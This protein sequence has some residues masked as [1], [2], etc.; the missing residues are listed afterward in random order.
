[1]LRRHRHADHRQVG[2]GGAA[3]G[4]V[5]STAG[6]GDD[7]LDTALASG[8]GPFHDAP[9]IA[10]RGTDLDLVLDPE[11]LENFDARLHQGEIGLGAENDADHWLQET[12]SSAMSVRKKAPSNRTCR[13][14]ASA[15]SRASATV[16]PSATDVTTRPPSVTR[17]FPGSNLVAA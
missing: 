8:S 16:S 4:E 11:L 2:P 14:P 9:R 3:A 7:D 1:M 10:V 13:A 15:F 6:G 17:P 5:S 12:A